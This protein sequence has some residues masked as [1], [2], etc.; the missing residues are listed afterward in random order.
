M[1]EPKKTQR[2]IPARLRTGRFRI[3]AADRATFA[4]RGAIGI[5]VTLSLFGLSQWL[6][7]PWLWSLWTLFLLFR[8]PYMV[9]C[10]MTDISPRWRWHLTVGALGLHT[11]FA[12]I[13]PWLMLLTL[14]FAHGY[15]GRTVRH[16]RGHNWL[17]RPA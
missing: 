16:A 11:L 15:P 4:R 1:T 9:L 17:L 2:K 7:L 8:I 6:A 10:R 14:A 13:Q 12:L 3:P 5:S